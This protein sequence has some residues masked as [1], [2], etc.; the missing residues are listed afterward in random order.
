M[1][2]APSLM[3]HRVLAL[4][5]WEEVEIN[6][7]P[8]YFFLILTLSYIFPENIIKVYQAAQKI[9]RIF[10]HNF[11]YFRQ[12]FGVFEISLL[13]KKLIKSACDRWCQHFF[14]CNFFVN[15]FIYLERFENL[16][17]SLLCQPRYFT[18]IQKHLKT[19]FE[20][21]QRLI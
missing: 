10:Y 12:F 18:K 5:Y 9:W 13:Q 2:K 14:R 21:R 6:L 7:T 17:H 8:P 20:H 15:R 4:N 3:F 11:I 1:Q 19:L 16:C